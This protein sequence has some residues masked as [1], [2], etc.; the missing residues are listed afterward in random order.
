MK[1]I[2]VRFLTIAIVL[3]LISVSFCYTSAYSQIVIDPGY[4]EEL[5]LQ[6]DRD[7]YF[8]GE[9][10]LVKVS[11]FN[12]LSGTLG[13]FSK[14]GYV[15]MYN[16]FGNPIA[17]AKVDLEDFSGATGFRIPDTLGSGNYYVRAYTSWMKNFP[18]EGFAYRTI[19][20]INPFENID[21]LLV[22]PTDVETDSLVSPLQLL[23]EEKI[24][25]K[26]GNNTINT[27]GK[28]IRIMDENPGTRDKV[29]I[30]IAGAAAGD[31]DFSMTVVKSVLLDENANAA[32]PVYEAGN[33][34]FNLTEAKYMPEL[35]GSVIRGTIRNN[36]T[37]EPLANTNV[38]LSFIGKN[39]RCQ[40]SKTDAGGRFNFFTKEKG[41]LNVVIAPVSELITDYYVEITDPFE[42]S[43]P[44]NS[45]SPVHIDTSK[46]EELN[47]AIIGMQIRNI[48]D[49][50]LRPDSVAPEQYVVNNFYGEP[51]NT[52]YLSDYIELTTL[53][54]VV[55]EIVPGVWTQKRNKQLN[56]KLLNKYPTGNF[57]KSPMVLFDGV[58]VR[59]IEE[60]LDVP[61]SEIERI[62]I[63]NTRY[64][65][66]DITMEGIV[67]FI[68]KKG[69]M[70]MM[71]YDKSIFRQLY[72][73]VDNSGDE[74]YYPDYSTAELKA[75]RI[76]DY[77]NTMYWDPFITANS[78]GEAVV[79]FYTADEEG[80]YTVIVEGFTKDGAY[81][82]NTADFTVTR[83]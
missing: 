60:V 54:E 12:G 45:Y 8:T 37:N 34:V 81:F 36:T 25:D 52:V 62:D 58:P 10:V 48:Y 73:S 68:S 16:K 76:P 23:A 71:E 69:D 2:K 20:V 4:Q 82:R 74:L 22:K 35:D 47:E 43:V 21:E 57:Y 14:V 32:K 63:F 50:Y 55:K 59:D 72:N 41:T 83:R 1:N 51:D 70:S 67:H 64:F 13:D 26:P 30:R 15:D 56:L 28:T 5:Y 31:P 18:L 42:L 61:A 38:M 49:P 3:I 79:D 11:K 39:A 53:R 33:F 9:E 65:V 17:Q 29:E 78:R 24:I 7:I 75:G 77:R 27:A 44:E 19:T 66:S 40:F 80:D 6:T 46:L